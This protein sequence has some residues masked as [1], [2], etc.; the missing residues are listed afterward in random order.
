MTKVPRTN[1]RGA[2][3]IVSLIMLAMVT[4]MVVAFV[5]FSR[6][7]RASVKASMVSTE[8][9]HSVM[10]A[11]TFAQEEVVRRLHDDSG[12]LDVLHVT[13]NDVPPPL[14]AAL[15][16]KEKIRNYSESLVSGGQPPVFIDRDGDGAQEYFPTYLD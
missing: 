8:A 9:E 15:N 6:L 1:E 11:L 7:E 5:G 12:D 4:F 10:G 16:T 13:M 14:M 2:V 3:L